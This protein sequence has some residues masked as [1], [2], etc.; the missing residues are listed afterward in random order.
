MVPLIMLTHRI[1]EKK[2]NSAIA[3]LEALVAIEGKIM[4][5]RCE[6]LDSN[7]K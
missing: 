2:M 4:R 5:I 1:A 3:Q 7:W 6:H